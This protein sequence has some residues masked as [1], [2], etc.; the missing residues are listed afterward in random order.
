MHT[1]PPGLFCRSSGVQHLK[2]FEQDA[3]QF[4]DHGEA[5]LG[6]RGCM[7]RSAF[8]ENTVVDLEMEG[9]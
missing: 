4:H 5:G 7:S 2:L 8:D 1:P 9:D 6:V 3:L